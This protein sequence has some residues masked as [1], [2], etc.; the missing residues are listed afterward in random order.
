M[1]F[2][3]V[4]LLAVVAAFLPTSNGE[5][6]TLQNIG[7]FKC[8]LEVLQ[9]VSREVYAEIQQESLN[10]HVANYP[11]DVVREHSNVAVNNDRSLASAWCTANECTP[12]HAE[13]VEEQGYY[14][15]CDK[16]V[17]KTNIR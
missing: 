15:F 9:D 11:E 17:S 7:N 4:S 3:S 14:T 13:G 2:L 12:F 5:C 10:A 6:L 1:K 16:I 8:P